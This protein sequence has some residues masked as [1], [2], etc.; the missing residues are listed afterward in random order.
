VSFLMEL[1]VYPVI[2][3]LIRRRQLSP[4]WSAPE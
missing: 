2:F 3:Y 1:L 4:E